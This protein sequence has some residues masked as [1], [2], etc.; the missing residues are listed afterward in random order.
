MTHHFSVEILFHCVNTR[1]TDRKTKILISCGYGR[2]SRTTTAY[3]QFLYGAPPTLRLGPSWTKKVTD[4]D[5]HTHTKPIVLQFLQR[6]QIHNYSD[7]FQ[8]ILLQN[9]PT[10]YENPLAEHEITLLHS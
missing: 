6:L 2:I 3:Q 7:S 10:I 4:T 8:R 5:G 1:R 9:N